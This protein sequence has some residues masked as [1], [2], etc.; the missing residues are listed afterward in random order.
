MASPQSTQCESQYYYVGATVDNQYELTSFIGTGGMACVYLAKEIGSPHQYALKF[1]KD[2]Y[3]YESYLV[4]Y[5]EDEASSM[6]DLAH[7]N[8]VRFYRFVNRAEYSYIVMDYVDGFS[9]SDVL[10][11]S[12]SK[13]ERIPLDEVVRVMTQIARALDAIHRESFVHRDIKPSNVLIERET[14]RAFLTDLGITSAQNTR[15]VGAGTIAYMSPEQAETWVA[16]QRADIYGYGIMLYEMLAGKRPFNVDDGLRGK[17]AE[18]DLLRKHKEAP[19]PNITDTRHDL[20]KEL[21]KI[22]AKAL[23]KVPDDRYQSVIEFA[24]DVHRVLVPKLADDLSDFTT[25]KH[26]YIAPPN[27]RANPAPSLA[28]RLLIGLGIVAIIVASMI[29]MSVIFA[30]SLPFI[31]SP[32]PT[33]TASPTATETPVPT[34]TPT[35]NPIESVVVR[36]PL[37]TGISAFAEPDASNSLL[38][39]P[40]EDEVFNYL[41]V[42]FVDGFRV[43][44]DINNTQ[45]VT[46]FGVAFRM[47]DMNNYHYFA[48]NPNTLLWDIVDVVEGVKTIQASGELAALPSQLTVSGLGNFFEIRSGANIITYESSLYPTGSLAIYLVDGELLLDDIQVSLIGDDARSGAIASPTPSIGLADPL[49]FLRADIDALLATNLPLDT[50]INCPDYI[51]IYDTLERHTESDNPDIVTIANDVLDTGYIVY[52]RCLIESPDATLSFNEFVQDYSEWESNLNR[53]HAELNG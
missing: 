53:I 1:L 40:N 19:I 15:M 39:V 49:R 18:A 3:H 34:L 23:A 44:L 25:I 11:L 5:F 47:Q 20:P 4:D 38:V 13:K 17:E 41:R 14:G 36:L 29:A 21:D 43:V 33:L 27:G 50:A 7:P 26:H 48:L 2:E 37:L 32:T 30:D 45:D 22:I 28:F 31:S 12:R 10:K 16:D 24:Q 35:A 51:S 6:R 52:Q 42:G 9:L 46:R 8:I